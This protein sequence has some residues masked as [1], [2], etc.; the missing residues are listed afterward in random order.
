M[1]TALKEYDENGKLTLHE[2]YSHNNGKYTSKILKEYG[3]NGKLLRYLSYRNY[4]HLNEA[5]A[6]F[7]PEREEVYTYYESGK[8][9]TKHI[10]SY[11]SSGNVQSSTFYEYDEKGYIIHEWDKNGNGDFTSEKISRYNES[12][13]RVFYEYYSYGNLSEKEAFEYG[14]HGGITKYIYFRYGILIEKVY[15]YN[16]YDMVSE[17]RTYTDSVLTERVTYTYHKNGELYSEI[18]YDAEGKITSEKYY[19][20]YGELI[21]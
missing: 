2:Q 13:E 12:G 6:D 15:D 18:A 7:R 8:T 5:E 20:E 11:S 16:E 9:K 10:T 21:P 4:Q 1:L 14:E 17:Q 3:E 19:N